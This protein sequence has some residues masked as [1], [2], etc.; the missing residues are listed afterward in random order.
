M[1]PRSGGV[2]SHQLASIFTARTALVKHLLS[3]AENRSEV[4]KDWGR[5]AP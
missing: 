5:K 1:M 4:L 3:T 2:I